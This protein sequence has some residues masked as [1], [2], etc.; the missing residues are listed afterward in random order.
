MALITE[1]GWR[2]MQTTDDNGEAQFTLIKE[3]FHDD[4]VD[5]SKSELYLL[6]LKHQVESSGVHQGESYENEH[7]IATLPFRVSPALSD[8][9]SKYMAYLA[10]IITIIG[11]A[12]AIAIRRRR[13]REQ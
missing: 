1:Q 7:Y 5:R 13:K 10:A 6:R 12:V 4:G 8:W 9:Q 3:D 2:Q 11:A